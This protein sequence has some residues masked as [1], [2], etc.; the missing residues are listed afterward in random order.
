MIS[1]SLGKAGRGGTSAG[2]CISFEGFQGAPP[3][4][5][6]EFRLSLS[7]VE[8]LRR[9][10]RIDAVWSSIE[11]LGRGL[12]LVI[13]EGVVCRRKKFGRRLFHADG[14]IAVRLLP[15][16]SY[17]LS[18]R[19]SATEPKSLSSDFWFSRSLE[20]ALDPL[21][22][23]FGQFIQDLGRENDLPRERDL[24]DDRLSRP[25]RS[26]SSG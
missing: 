1:S 24:E 7:E 22:S 16:I 12:L 20:L 9:L 26:S 13:F 21:L 25:S 17:G 10:E 14:G 8:R 15:A 19:R 5:W 4:S 3:L 6:D 18:P 2:V 23:L 11:D